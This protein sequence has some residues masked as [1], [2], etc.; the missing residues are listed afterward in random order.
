LRR[1]DRRGD[2]AIADEVPDWPRDYP[3]FH[4]RSPRDRRTLRARAGRPGAAGGRARR[5][6]P[7]AAPGGRLAERKPRR[8][9]DPRPLRGPDARYWL[10]TRPPD[11]RPG[12]TRHPRPRH[13]HHAVRRGHGPVLG[14]AGHAARRLRPRAGDRP[15]D[16]GAAGGWEHRDRRRPGGPAPPGGR[17]PRAAGPGAGRT[18]AARLSAPPRAGPAVP[19]RVGQRVVPLGLCRRRSHH[20]RGVRRRARPSRHL[21]GRRTVVR[22]HRHWRPGLFR[23]NRRHAVTECLPPGPRM[24]HPPR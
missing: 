1:R 19:R 4:G 18:R 12:R 2:R 24:P 20:R 6:Q 3:G 17:T 23:T 10:G 5:R 16:H 15:L 11:R 9:I 21:D 22:L 14:R 7:Q 8:Q 13:R